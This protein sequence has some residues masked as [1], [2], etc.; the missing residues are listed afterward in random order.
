MR[1]RLFLVMSFLALFFVWPFVSRAETNKTLGSITTPGRAHDVIVVG[2]FAYVADLDSGIV[3]LNVTTPSSPSLVATYPIP[4]VTPGAWTLDI[5][6]QALY[7]V[8]GGQLV[9]YNISMAIPPVLTQQGVYGGTPGGLQVGGVVSDGTNAYVTGYIGSTYYVQVVNVTNPAVPVLAAGTNTLAV[10]ATADLTLAGNYLY[11]VGQDASSVNRLEVI[12]A[13]P[14]LTVAGT[15]T[16]PDNTSNYQGV[17]VYG[18]TAYI[19]DN[20]NGF[21]AVTIANPAAPTASFHEASS[22]YSMGIAISNG[23]AFLTRN[24]NG[25]LAVYDIASATT[26]LFVVNYSGSGT[27]GVDGSAYAVAVAN[28]VAYVAGIN[29]IQVIDVS[30]PDLEPPVVTPAGDPTPVVQPGAKYVDPGVTTDPGTT[31]MVTGTVD[32]DKVG[33][34]VLTYT[35]TDRAGNVTTVTRTVYVA[36][37]LT[38]LTLRNNKLTIKVGSNSVTLNPFPGYRGAIL[39]RKAVVDKKT[40]PVYFFVATD[41]M[42]RPS[43]VVYNYQ[44][45]LVVRHYLTTI[46]TK[47]LQVELVSNPVTASIFVAIAPKTNG[48]IVT[49]YNISKGGTKS[50]GTV[51]ITAGKGTVLMKFLKTYTQ[52]YGLVTKP[53]GTTKSPVV[54][55]YSGSKKKFLKDAAFNLT[56]LA[57]TKTSLGL[58]P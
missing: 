22:R 56:K 41:A 55:R 43:L 9:T 11:V 53:R 57:W 19:N 6:D 35:V 42:S 36:P 12:N 14:I 4:G 13:Y 39:A 40:N 48:L 37:T 27:T 17:Q 54:W 51:T 47:G 49:V 30:H 31:T 16:E 46:S 23:Y 38:K 10:P 5:V 34:Y 21:R 26:P 25:G 44:G 58:A 15:Y 29:G 7:A 52:E 2:D 3:V 28:N 32:T 33:K 24:F 20:I 45:K 50:L 8:G 18:S 1:T